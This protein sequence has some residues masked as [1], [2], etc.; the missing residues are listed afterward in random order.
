MFPETKPNIYIPCFQK[1][2]GNVPQYFFFNVRFALK[3]CLTLPFP[4]KINEHVPLFPQTPWRS[5]TQ[6]VVFFYR[7]PCYW[8]GHKQ[9]YRRNMYQRN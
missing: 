7:V 6:R 5:L 9:C 4:K 8:N 2:I 1:V 3:I